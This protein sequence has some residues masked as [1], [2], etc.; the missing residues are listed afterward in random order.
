STYTLDLPDA[1]KARRINPT[2]HI[3]RLHPH[4]ENDNKLFPHRDA[5][6]WYDFGFDTE[7]EWLVDEIIGHRW[8]GARVEF[9]VRWNL[10]DTTWEPYA[11]CKDLAALDLYLDAMGVKDWQKLARHRQAEPRGSDLDP[12]SKKPQEH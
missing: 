2:F 11:N 7:A 3:S 4:Y 9:E 1:L 12:R 10:G 6:A 8:D 5:K